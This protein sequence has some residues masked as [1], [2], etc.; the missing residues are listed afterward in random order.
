MF[1]SQAFEHMGSGGEGIGNNHV[2]AAVNVTFVHLAHHFRVFCMGDSAPGQVVHLNA[3]PLNLRTGASIQ[4][5]NI[6][7][8]Y[9]VFDDSVAH[10]SLFTRFP[11][12][13]KVKKPVGF[14]R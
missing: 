2:R 14:I 8:I 13:P 1:Q 3:P 9:L 6:S 4:Q 7:I 11:V 10:L 5:D 12:Q